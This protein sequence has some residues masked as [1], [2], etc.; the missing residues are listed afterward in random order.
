MSNEFEIGRTY[1]LHDRDSS[2][3]FR[4]KVTK[5][6]KCTVTFELSEAAQPW[7]RTKSV[8]LRTA[9]DSNLY[10]ADGNKLEE[11][12]GTA[13]GDEVFRGI[14]YSPVTRRRLYSLAD[15][16]AMRQM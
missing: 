6:T 13:K 2:A 7:C 12:R 10:D 11:V 4:A 8:T 16:E 14:R 3:H 1:I 5:R 9:K 15:M